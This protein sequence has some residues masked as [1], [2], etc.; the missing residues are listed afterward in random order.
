MI[1][2]VKV[3]GISE[4]LMNNGKMHGSGLPANYTVSV[5]GFKLL[6]LLCYNLDDNSKSIQPL[7]SLILI[8]SY[9]KYT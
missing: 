6:F 5:L 7:I 1:I 9:V 3:F 4:S 2:H 8:F